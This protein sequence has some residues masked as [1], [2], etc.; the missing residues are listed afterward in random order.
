[1]CGRIAL[2]SDPPH[3]ARLFD[4]GL[5]PEL[6]DGLTPHWNIGPT[7]TILGVSEDQGGQRM[8]RAYRWGLVPG[9]AKDPSTLRNTFNA[10]AESVATKPMFQS[11]F[12]RGRI[13]VPADAFYE[14]APGPPKQ[15]YAFRRAD[16]EPVVFAGLREWWRGDDGTEIHSASVITTAAG[17]DMPIHN[18]QPVVLDRR[19]WEQWLDPT[20]KDTERLERLLVP[21]AAGT[22]VHYPVRREVG[23]VRNDRPDLIDDMTAV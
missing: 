18:R 1:M 15:P 8:V 11:A 5:D 2:Y 13:L 7:A 10:R 20:T 12:R 21:G 4:A 16:G 14:W 3:L 17:P 23:N 22:L 6:A 9:W 19:S